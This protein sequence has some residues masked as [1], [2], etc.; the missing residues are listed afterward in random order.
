MFFFVKEFMEWYRQKLEGL[1]GASLAV[2]P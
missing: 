2:K 1:D